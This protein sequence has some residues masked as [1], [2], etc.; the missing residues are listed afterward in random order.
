M[1]YSGSLP[2]SERSEQNAVENASKYQPTIKLEIT[3]GQQNVS[4]LVIAQSSLATI[5]V[6]CDAVTRVV[7][8][9]QWPF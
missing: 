7:C 9:W 3:S 4:H 5:S 6:V 1:E 8:Q 2:N